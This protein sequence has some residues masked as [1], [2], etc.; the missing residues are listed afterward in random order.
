MCRFRLGIGLFAIVFAAALTGCGSTTM[1]SGAINPPPGFPTPTPTPLASPTPSPMPTPSPSP[2]PMGGPSPSPTPTPTVTAASRFLFGTPGFESGTLQAGTIDNSGKVSA[3]TGSPFGEGLGQASIIQVIADPSG[4]F[5]YVLNVEASAVGQM[6]GQPGLCGFSINHQT[7]ALA[8]VPGS[9]IQFPVRNNNFLAIDGTGHFLFEPNGFGAA[10]ST[11]FDVYSIDQTSGALT[12]TTANSNA[13]P[14]GSY[15]I[16]STDG[17]FLF[18]A[19]GGM[20]EAFTMSIQTG[21]LTA[22]GTPISTAGSAGPM[23]LTADGM[24]L[25][26]ANQT[27]GTVAIFAVG[28]GGRLTATPGSPFPIDSGAQFLTLAPSG[29]FLYV[30]AF[31]GASNTVKGYAVNPSAGTF[32]PIANAVVNNVT[33]VTLDRSGRFAY[34]SDA[35]DLFTY[36]IDPT[37]GALTQL[38]HT[39]GPSSDDATDMAT[40]Q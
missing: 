28:A 38:F 3:V 6:I 8:L 1:V 32:T 12:K 37:T 34:I 9:P 17:Q 25:Y 7:G 19:G 22:A 16:T 14:V 24:F 27:E 2:T 5:V 26:V 4:R 29:T 35:G 21:E 40:T 31:P 15:S 10:N 39:T 33:T 13:P 30:A 11:G 20:V 36:S 23:A 18:N